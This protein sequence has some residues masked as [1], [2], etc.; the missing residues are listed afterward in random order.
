MPDVSDDPS[1]QA[2]VDK[3]LIVY[4]CL[5][6]DEAK[7]KIKAMYAPTIPHPDDAE[8]LPS[9]DPRVASEL[10]KCWA[11]MQPKPLHKLKRFSIQT[12]D[13]LF[14]LANQF[15]TGI[16]KPLYR[17][18]S[19][20]EWPLETRLERN[21][22]EFVRTETGL[23][24]YE[25]RV[26]TEAQRRLHSFVEKLPDDG[27]LLSWLALLRHNGVPTRL[28]DA[29][30]SLYVA[31]YFA[32]RDARPNCDAAIWIFNRM[33][34]DSEFTTWS[35]GADSSYL[36]SSPFTVAQYGDPY[37]WP[38]PKS[39]RDRTSPP[40]IDSL[41]AGEIPWLDY[42]ATLDAGLRGYIE[43]P[44]LAVAEPFWL[45]RRLDVQQGAFLIP[46]NI[47][48]GFQQNLMSHLR[49]DLEG[50]SESDV[51]QNQQDL[52][53]LWGSFKVI[54]LRIPFALHIL[55]RI[56]LESMNIRELTLLPDL[57]GALAHLSGFL[58]VNGR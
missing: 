6:E 3:E 5:F 56:K 36:R 30:R 4:W 51:P 9:S 7:T 49:L 26:L 48:L 1:A 39:Q 46:F 2:G 33:S 27:D 14:R 35:H 23:E 21:V 25:Y 22:P 16:P 32:L 19:S 58:P 52:F 13:D 18:Q 20:Y 11:A 57:E 29:T 28:L 47:R 37:Y 40:T 45:S 17:G 34:I 31:C 42:A 8:P 43:T 10:Q 41:R 55:L 24:V 38:M 15:D 54:K 44:G 50:S 12:I 53:E